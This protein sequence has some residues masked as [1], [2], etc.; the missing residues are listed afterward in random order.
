M[1]EIKFICTS[2]IA[3]VEV[4][5]VYILGKDF[6]QIRKM[7]KILFWTL[8]IG[9]EIFNTANNLIDFGTD[10]VKFLYLILISISFIIGNRRKNVWGLI[11]FFCNVLILRSVCQL[12]KL[13]FLTIYSG[14]EMDL[15]IKNLNEFSLTMAVFYIFFYI[16]GYIFTK[17][18]WRQLTLCN[19]NILHI[20]SL[21]ML[22]LLVTMELV[23]EWEQILITMPS[24]LLLLVAVAVWRVEVEKKEKRKLQHYKELEYQMKEMD[25]ELEEIRYEVEKYYQRAGERS[26][27]YAE[28]ILKKIEKAKGE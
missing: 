9:Y 28:Q 11:Y 16:P 22:L 27:D 1:L 10:T 12:F 19:E 18:L 23:N 4:L 17:H 2:I 14:V 15:V 7:T 6:I 3:L 21:I 26:T 20:I 13:F 8:F 5:A 24:L 25:R